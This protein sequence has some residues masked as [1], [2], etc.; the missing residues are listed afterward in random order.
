M[1]GE[2]GERWR[3]AFAVLQHRKFPEGA[4][5]KKWSL[6]EKNGKLQLS[7]LV[8]AQSNPLPE[9]P[10]VK[11]AG[12][13]IGWR[14]MPGNSLR[15]GVLYEDKKETFRELRFNL[16]T[17]PSGTENHRPFN[18]DFGATRWDVR[19]INTLLPDWDKDDPL[20]TAFNM[21]AILAKR[22]SD[23]LNETKSKLAEHLGEET[24]TWWPKVGRKGLCK[25]MVEPVDNG[26]KKEQFTLYGDPKAES[27]LRA[28]NK[29]DAELGILFSKYCDRMTKRMD[30]EHHAVAYDICAYLKRQGINC[31]RIESNFMAQVAGV[32]DNNA[33]EALKA[34]QKYRQFVGLAKFIITLKQ[35]A[36]KEGIIV[37]ECEASNTS[38]IHYACGT[39][40]VGTEDINFICAGCGE[41]I[42]QDKN[43]AVNLSRSQP[44]KPKDDSKD[45]ENEA[46]DSE[47]A[48]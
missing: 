48:A 9:Q 23:M 34:S 14:M 37:Q 25:M 38:R 6:I 47:R 29:K 26:E 27:I 4:H 45:K 39:L 15:F 13:D 7:L 3:F 42:D 17:P 28:W 5:L 43:A 18:I 44:A 32:K 31:L 19:N 22:R 12:L 41:E 16:T 21:R 10:N 40:N 35:V 30:N 8:E 36:G 11:S 24:P 46:S 1:R 2:T 20:P 33:S